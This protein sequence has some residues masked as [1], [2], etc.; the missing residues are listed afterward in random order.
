MQNVDIN[1]T[2]DAWSSLGDVVFVPHTDEE[3]RRSSP[4]FMV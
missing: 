1:K 4:Y 3:Y 2:A